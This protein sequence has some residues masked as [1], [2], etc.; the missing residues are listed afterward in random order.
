MS[1]QGILPA[2]VL[3]RALHT[4]TLVATVCAATGASA[5][6]IKVDD[7]LRGFTT[8][9]AQCALQPQAV[10]VGADGQDF[11]VRYYLST[12]GGQGSR[13]VVFLN[14][15]NLAQL[16][17][18]TWQ[19]IMPPK[20]HVRGPE[21]MDV[22]TDALA[23]IAD[24]F[25]RLAKT[26]AIYLGRIGVDGTSGNHLARKTELELHVVNAA[27][28]A[29]KQRHGFE[30]FHLAGQSGGSRLL[31]G[32]VAMR[33]DIA[34]AVAGSGRLGWSVTTGFSDPGRVFF[35]ILQ[36][37]PVIAK[38]STLRLVLVTDPKDKIV[39]LAEKTIF[40][41]KMREAGRPISQFFVDASDD[42]HHSV[43]DYTRL[44]MAGCILGKSD[45]DIATAVNTLVKRSAQLNARK[46]AEAALTS[47]AK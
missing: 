23:K 45:G 1:S 42:D 44:V 32:L 7:M 40:V 37:A 41:E 22:D 11:C 8:T 33:H 14:G 4:M 39:P 19:W 38:N 30:G 46:L 34:C 6:I 20:D 24:D 25:S 26:T 16:N 9:R 17:E 43:L 47:G 36:S 28:A 27:L 13:P 12:V 29:I 21:M 3:R 5:T 18:K 15:D 35:N 31:G 2:G 10:W